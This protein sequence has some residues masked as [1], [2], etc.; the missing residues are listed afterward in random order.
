MFCSDV[1]RERGGGGIF[2][3]LIFSF[4]FLFFFFFWILIGGVWRGIPFLQ[5]GRSG[6]DLH[7]PIPGS[8]AEC[9]SIPGDANGCDSLVIV[10]AALIALAFRLERI[11]DYDAAVGV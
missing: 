1:E 10:S 2:F 9:A 5:T 3:S 8:R 11:P 6:P 4:S 7:E